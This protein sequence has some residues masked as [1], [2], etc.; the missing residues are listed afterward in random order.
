MWESLRFA[1]F[2][3][4]AINVK[5]QFIGLTSVKSIDVQTLKSRD[6]FDFF[7]SKHSKQSKRISLTFY[8]HCTLYERNYL[9]GC[10]STD[11]HEI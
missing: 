6:L 4:I 2:T 1:H 9:L 3:D 7:K 11:M 5:S 10:A 8:S